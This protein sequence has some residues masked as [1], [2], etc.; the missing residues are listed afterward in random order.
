MAVPLVHFEAINP[1]EPWGGGDRLA[2][3]RQIAAA[4]VAQD[5]PSPKLVVDVGSFTGE[6]LEAFLEKFPA[7]IEKFY[8]NHGSQ[9]WMIPN[10]RKSRSP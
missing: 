4:V 10:L 5:N 2:L 1:G 3:P 7:G 8:R 9:A 6:F